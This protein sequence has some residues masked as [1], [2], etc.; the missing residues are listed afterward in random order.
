MKYM[1]MMH[2]PRAG[3]KDAGIGTW[4]M[5]DIKAHIAFM[6]RFNKELTEAGELV[7]RAGS[8][9][10]RRSANRPCRQGWRARGH[11]RAVS[12]GEGVPRRLL[13]CRLRQQG[14]RVRARG[15][16]VGGAGQG[17]RADEH[18]H[19]SARSDERAASR[20]V[21]E[22]E[23][24]RRGRAPAA[25]ACAAGAGRGRPPLRRFRRRRGRR[26]GG[27][28]RGRPAVAA[29]RRAR[30][31]A[32][33]ADPGRRAAHD[34]PVSRR[35]GAPSPRGCRHHAGAGGR[36]RRAAAGQPGRRCRR[37]TRSSSCSCAVTRR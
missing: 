11:R 3:W 23:L 8:R 5:D 28:P 16:R 26:A 17:R 6:M 34:R 18:A 4:P 32:R 33:L 9:R 13:D 35:H 14:S 10:P 24:E 1:L 2:A 12:G 37:T 21:T 19:R 36:A 29:G 31:S 22:L 20:N 15:A 7:G 25:R 30:Q 27:A